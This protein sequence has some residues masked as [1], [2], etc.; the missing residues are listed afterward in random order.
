MRVAA[1]S[2]AATTWYSERSGQTETRRRR[3]RV[4]QRVDD[5]DGWSARGD[6]PVGSRLQRYGAAGQLPDQ[7]PLLGPYDLRKSTIA[8]LHP[9]PIRIGPLGGVERTIPAA[10]A[11]RRDFAVRIRE[12]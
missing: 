8:R 4:R 11:Q 3:C 7:A 10:L 5:G 12:H 9:V 6:R 2:P 1:Y